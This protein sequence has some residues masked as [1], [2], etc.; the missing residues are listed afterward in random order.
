MNPKRFWV[1]LAVNLL[2]KKLSVH[3][4]IEFN[5]YREVQSISKRGAYVEKM[6]QDP[7]WRQNRTSY[8]TKLLGFT[9]HVLKIPRMLTDVQGN[10]IKIRDRDSGEE[11]MQLILF[12][13]IEAWLS[14]L[15]ISGG[16][17]WVTQ[18]TN[19][20]CTVTRGRRQLFEPI[21]G[22]AVFS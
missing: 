9:Q 11:K 1:P 4:V 21:I 20:R 13:Y 10:I 8:S 2:H 17:F 18:C 16:I 5:L 15:F 22:N 14:V 6:S 12:A 7:V 19:S 3:Y